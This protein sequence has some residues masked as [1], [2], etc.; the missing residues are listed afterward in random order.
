MFCQR[1]R[2]R[3]VARVGSSEATID[4]AKHGDSVNNELYTLSV[5][6]RAGHTPVEH[7]H[8]VTPPVVPGLRERKTVRA[9]RLDVGRRSSRRDH[10]W[11]SASI[12]SNFAAA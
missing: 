7:F 3:A 10:S 9:R 12:G 2:V 1:S 6:R 8:R 5:S 4:R 11:R